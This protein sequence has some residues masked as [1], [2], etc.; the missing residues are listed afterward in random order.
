MTGAARSPIVR[1]LR[2][3]NKGRTM[4]THLRLI[5]LVTFLTGAAFTMLALVQAG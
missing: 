4:L 1:K 3:T 5:T 2:R